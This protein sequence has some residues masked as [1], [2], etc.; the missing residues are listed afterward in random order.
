MSNKTVDLR[1][2]GRVFVKYVKKAK[3]W[4]KTSFTEHGQKQEWF[5]TEEEARR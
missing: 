2:L 5:E 4:C 1:M 3:R